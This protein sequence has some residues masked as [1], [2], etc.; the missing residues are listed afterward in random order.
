[1]NGNYNGIF[2]DGSYRSI[3]SC[4]LSTTTKPD[5]TE[6]DKIGQSKNESI[7]KVDETFQKKQKL[8]GKQFC[9]V[10]FDQIGKTNKQQEKIT[11]LSFAAGNVEEPQ[12][13]RET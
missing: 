6:N 4:A 11:K 2:S 13:P 8:K 7:F 12:R 3:N 1:M 10:L 9:F 5:H